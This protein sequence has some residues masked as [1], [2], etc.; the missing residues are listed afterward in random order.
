MRRRRARVTRNR[1]HR[2]NEGTCQ[3]VFDDR[4]TTT[5]SDVDWGNEKGGNVKGSGLGDV[6]GAWGRCGLEGSWVIRVRKAGMKE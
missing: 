2:R 4:H 3:Q 5:M 6:R 1:S